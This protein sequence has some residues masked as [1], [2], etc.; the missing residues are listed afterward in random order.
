[1]DETNVSQPQET[2]VEAET[3]T[4]ETDNETETV[5]TASDDE[6]QTEKT[7]TDTVDGEQ[8]SSADDFSLDIKYNK[9]SR[10]LNR[11]DATR[12]AQMGLKFESLQPTIKKLQYLAAA[13]GQT[14]EG[15]VDGIVN[16][17]EA[18]KLEK[19]KAK[20]NGDEE[21][22]NALIEADKRK[23]GKAYDDMIAAEQ[24]AEEESKQDEIKTLANEFNTLQKEIPKFSDNKFE[25][26]PEEVL[27]IREKNNITLLDAYLRYENSNRLKAEKEKQKQ[28][29]NAMHSTGSLKGEGSNNK[30]KW[31]DEL[32]KGIWG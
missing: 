12:Y 27:K 6:V 11:E 9:V 1:M 8:E 32:L 14:F 17:V 20:A 30:P 21:I 31:E 4:Q 15:L 16:G 24:K 28:F 13:D 26:V 3:T 10:S 2:V 18:D 22:L 19:F 5:D 25:S 23:A 29:D 7:E